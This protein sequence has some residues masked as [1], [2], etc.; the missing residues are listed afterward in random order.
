[1]NH[2]VPRSGILIRKITRVYPGNL[3]VQAHQADTLGISSK[4]AWRE[5]WQERQPHLAPGHRL[6]GTGGQMSHDCR[7]QNYT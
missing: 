1:M 2:P 5:T 4:E 3:Q 6:Q 7:D